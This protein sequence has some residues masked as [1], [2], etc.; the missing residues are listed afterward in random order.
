MIYFLFILFVHTVEASTHLQTII[1]LENQLQKMKDLLKMNQDEC[2]QSIERHSEEI[3]LL[4]EENI[5]L[6]H[7]LKKGKVSFYFRMKRNIKRTGHN[8]KTM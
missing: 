8:S 6:L 7:A 4:E 3:R 5:N 1:N 2:H